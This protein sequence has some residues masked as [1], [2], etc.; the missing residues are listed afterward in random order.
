MNKGSARTPFALVMAF[1]AVS[2]LTMFGQS[3]KAAMNFN[4]E[5]MDSICA[6]TGSH[7]A[8]MAKT[9]GMGND[10]ETCT[11]KCVAMGA[12][13]VLYDPAT[14]AMYSV[15]N[16]DK[17]AQFAGQRVRVRGMMEGSTIRVITITKLS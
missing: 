11:T 12:K 5:V 17:I 6:P 3:G 15:D 4:G 1:L 8:T 9:P 2:F 13:Y 7:A 14:H 10:S 16:P